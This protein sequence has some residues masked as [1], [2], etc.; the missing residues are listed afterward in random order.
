MSA[1]LLAALVLLWGGVIYAEMPDA[2][3]TRREPSS[4]AKSTTVASSKP[5]SSSA[6]SPELLTPL[7]L[8]RYQ[9]TPP[10]TPGVDEKHTEYEI[11][12]FPPGLERFTRMDSDQ[13]LFERIRQ[14]TYRRDPNERV[15]FPESPILSRERYRGRGNVW[16]VRQMTVEPNLL[17]YHHLYFEDK[18]SERYGWDLQAIQPVVCLFEFWF[19]FVSLPMKIGNNLCDCVES[20]AGYCLPGDPVPYLLYPPEITVPGTVAELGTIAALMAIFP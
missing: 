14:E 6:T 16:P 10:R 8:A 5:A 20:N 12:V 9:Y 13:K 15:E 19:D 17:Y 4:S 3:P 18:N 1:R 7:E 2:S 11:Q